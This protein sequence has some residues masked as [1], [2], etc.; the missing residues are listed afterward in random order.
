VSLVVGIHLVTTLAMFGVILFVQIVHY[1]LMAKVGRESSAAY[2]KAH[3]DRTG[4]VVGPLMLPEM[5]TAVWLA[6][7][8]PSPD[9]A[10]A[11][12]IGLALLVGVWLVTGVASVPCHRRLLDG[13]DADTHRRLVRT[14]WLRTVLWAGRVPIALMLAGWVPRA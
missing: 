13:F 9:L 2:A 5:A 4:L 14:N 7:V 11:G 1:P 12:R 6:A 10:A 3:T 8:P